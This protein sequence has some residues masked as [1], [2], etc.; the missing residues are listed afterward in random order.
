MKK[1]VLSFIAP[2]ALL[3]C[4]ASFAQG[5]AAAASANAKIN[6]NAPVAPLVTTAVV[7]APAASMPGKVPGVNPF[8]G[9]PLSSEQIQ[10]E[11]EESKLLTQTLEEALKQTNIREELTNVPLRKA[12]EAAQARTSVRKEELAIS[13]MDDAVK[14]TR[15]EANGRAKS[16]QLA[17]KALKPSKKELAE[18][19]AMASAPVAPPPAVRPTLLSVLEIGGKRSVV[20]DFAGNTLVAADGDNTPMGPVRVVD[21][22]SATLGGQTFKVSSSTLSRFTAAEPGFVSAKPPPPGVSS[23]TAYLGAPNSGVGGSPVFAKPPPTGM[24]QQS[25]LPPLQLPPGI[26][27]LNN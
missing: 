19:A 20:L 7:V 8:T 3:A 4:S 6:A 24:G 15:E 2:F 16:M 12:V 14:A 21:N 27:L 17:K 23:T 11:L 22:Q 13:S 25:Q 5:L 9:K 10:R 1:T 26:K 18:A